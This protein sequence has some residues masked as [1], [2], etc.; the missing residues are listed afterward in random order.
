MFV[1][2]HSASS[3]EGSIAFSQCLSSWNG[4]RKSHSR[5]ELWIL[6]ISGCAQKASLYQLL[7][8]T[9]LLP[10]ETCWWKEW[11]PLCK[12]LDF[13]FSLVF[14][15]SLLLVAAELIYWGLQGKGGD[16][17]K[18][19]RFFDNGR[20]LGNVFCQNEHDLKLMS[21]WKHKFL[22]VI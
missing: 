19:H 2:I 20:F 12:Y 16:G 21:N 1:W 3:W 18:L 22:K 15:S 17:I 5:E 4:V 11:S 14:L 7:P 8:V 6:G 10:W 9:F 13:F